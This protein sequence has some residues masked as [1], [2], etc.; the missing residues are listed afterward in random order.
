MLILTLSWH[1]ACTFLSA[2]Q[3]HTLSQRTSCSLNDKA[4]RFLSL[5]T[6]QE[7]NAE[8][9]ENVEQLMTDLDS[10][11]QDMISRD[12]E[13]EKL[14][15]RL[16]ERQVSSLC[17]FS[18]VVCLQGQEAGSQD[19]GAYEAPWPRPT[20]PSKVWQSICLRLLWHRLAH[21]A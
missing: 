8:L 6:L 14:E 15:A 5:W 1:P 3:H 16:A 13:I 9:E 11:L 21:Y 18:L 12:E 19:R 2:T 4:C 7:R 10:S 20:Y 17:S